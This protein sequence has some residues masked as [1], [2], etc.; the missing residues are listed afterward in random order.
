L[1]TK[2]GGKLSPIAAEGM[3]LADFSMAEVTPT[4]GPIVITS[5]TESTTTAGLYTFVFP[6]ATS[7]DVLRISNPLVGPL[8]KNLDLA[9]FDVTIP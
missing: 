3:E 6:S 1:N 2:Y 5:V 4:P 9:S 7:A 8:S